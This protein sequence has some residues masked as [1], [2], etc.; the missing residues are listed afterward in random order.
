MQ[1]LAETI[2][3]FL[4]E[5]LH[6]GGTTKVAQRRLDSSTPPRVIYDES[7]LRNNLGDDHELIAM[8]LDTFIADAPRQLSSLREATARGDGESARR[9]A[10]SLKGA[11]SN[12]GAVAIQKL[13][14]IAEQASRDG[15]LARVTSLVD[16]IEDAL[17]QFTKLIK[18][19]GTIRTT[20]DIEAR[21]AR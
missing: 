5:K 18:P 7:V 4:A 19:R 20:G 1:V 13:A 3:R 17:A 8:V 12:V 6:G 21:A 11:A 16:E 15:D 10:H 2:E 9:A 14:Q